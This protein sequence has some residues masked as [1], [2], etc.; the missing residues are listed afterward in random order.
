MRLTQLC[1]VVLL[2]TAPVVCWAGNYV[3]P[4]T[5][6]SAETSNNPSAAPSFLAQA[7]GNRGN[8]NVS[9]LDVHSL[10]SSGLKTKVYAHLMLWFG[11]SNHMNV[12][13]SSTD[14]AQVHRQITDMISR[15]IN[16]VIIDWYGSN[17]FEDQATRVVMAE[18]E[19]H[20]GF[21]F[22]IM[23]DHTPIKSAS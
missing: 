11:K 21:T 18:A 20:R 17:T 8:G 13:Y 9:K 14:P 22:A 4:T 7:N 23:F 2:L 16:G 6:L 19:S 12:G 10:L 15:G 5:T 1:V 3:V